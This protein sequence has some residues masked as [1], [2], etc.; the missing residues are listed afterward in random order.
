MR[1]EGE[2][3]G[4][5]KCVIERPV[6]GRGHQLFVFRRLADESL[7]C[8]CSTDNGIEHHV[9]KEMDPFPAPFMSLYEGN[10]GVAVAIAE[11]VRSIGALDIQDEERARLSGALEA[12]QAHLADMRELVFSSSVSRQPTNSPSGTPG[13]E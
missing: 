6:T 4:G 8:L 12:T 10:F 5:W 13:I 9:I 7:E 2:G 1:G 3:P 11:A